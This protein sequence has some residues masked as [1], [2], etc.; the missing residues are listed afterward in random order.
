MRL[1]GVRFHPGGYPRVE[2]WGEL[3][4]ATAPDLDAFVQRV[5]EER[6]GEPLVVDLR[7]VWFCDVTGLRSLWWMQTYAD[8][9]GA[10]LDLRE[11]DSVARTGRLVAQLRVADPVA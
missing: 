11:S 2:V 4:M 1:F 8:E 10:V 7:R 3:C 6:P 5:M 9:V